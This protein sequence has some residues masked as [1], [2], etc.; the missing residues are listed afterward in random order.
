[1][2]SF[3]SLLGEPLELRLTYLVTLYLRV[4]PGLFHTG[5][6]EALCLSL[7]TMPW[8]VSMNLGDLL[9]RGAFLVPLGSFCLSFCFSTGRHQS[10]I[11]LCKTNPC[12][13]R[14]GNV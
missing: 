11:K 3:C 12:A 14:G 1:M 8:E 7:G 13:L 10:K 2:L 5:W 4:P 9:K 6:A